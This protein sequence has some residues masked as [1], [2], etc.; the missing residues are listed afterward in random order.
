MNHRHVAT[1]NIKTF[2]VENTTFD[3][4]VNLIEKCNF[5]KWI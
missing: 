2:Q 3:N 1:T 5:Q 4:N